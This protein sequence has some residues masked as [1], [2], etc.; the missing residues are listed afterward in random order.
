MQ[1]PAPRRHLELRPRHTKATRSGLRTTL[2][3]IGG[4]VVVASR[5][6]I[7]VLRRRQR[8]GVLFLAGRVGPVFSIRGP[9]LQELYRIADLVSGERRFG[10]LLR[11][12]GPARWRLRIVVAGNARS[13]RSRSEPSHSWDRVSLWGQNRVG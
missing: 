13:V 8:L 12:A 2:G 3:S 7:R 9:G 5:E 11:P 10:R 1:R 6:G 4:R